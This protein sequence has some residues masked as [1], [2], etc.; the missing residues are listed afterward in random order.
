MDEVFNSRAV[1][2]EHEE[3]LYHELT[4]PTESAILERNAELRKD[5]GTIKDL[6]ENMGRG[7]S[8]GR[9]VASIPFV[10]YERA[11]RMG[12]AL[13]APG[14]HGQKEMMRFLGSELGKQCLVR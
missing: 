7:E 11:L 3:K 14:E 5:P 2:Q 10:I 13:N 4:Q 6:G 1:Y 12:Y 9:Q 8:W